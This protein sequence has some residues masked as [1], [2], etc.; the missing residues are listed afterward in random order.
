MEC[1]SKNEKSYFEFLT[2]CLFLEVLEV[3]EMIFGCWKK[4]KNKKNMVPFYGWFQ[5]PHYE[6][7]VYFLPKNW[8]GGKSALFI[9]SSFHQKTI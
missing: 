9:N 5:L 1:Y 3:E 6:G 7:T 8:L 2:D 4:T